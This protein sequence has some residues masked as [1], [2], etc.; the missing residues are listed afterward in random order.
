MRAMISGRKS[1]WLAKKD[2]A[3]ETNSS[4]IGSSRNQQKEKDL[5]VKKLL[6]R[7]YLCGNMNDSKRSARAFSS[8]ATT[9]KISLTESM[10]RNPC[11]SS[12]MIR[13]NIV[14][15]SIKRRQ[16]SSVI[17][18]V[19]VTSSRV[20]MSEAFIHAGHLFSAA[21]LSETSLWEITPTTLP[22][23]FTTPTAR[24]CFSRKYCA[25]WWTLVSSVMENTSLRD[26]MRSDTFTGPSAG[27]SGAILGPTPPGMQDENRGL[28]GDKCFPG[29]GPG[30][31]VLVCQCGLQT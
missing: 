28:T 2:R 27:H 15:W 11:R 17:S 12:S 16:S 29:E 22:D 13:W 19:T 4:R 18:G 31:A 8:D 24:T 5:P 10:P 1:L 23:A 25:V 14:F 30:R 20:M 26:P 21:T 3:K 7:P 9:R 6:N